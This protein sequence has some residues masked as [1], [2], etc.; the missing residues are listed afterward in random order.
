MAVAA[1]VLSRAVPSDPPTCWVVF[2][3]ALATPESAVADLGQGGAAEG[4]EGQTETHAHQDLGRQ[5]MGQKDVCTPI[6]VSQAKPS[7]PTSRPTDHR[8]PGPDAGHQSRRGGRGHDD[9]AGEGEEGHARPSGPSSAGP[10][11]SSS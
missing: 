1:I 2:T 4:G 5:D 8:H 3:R 11:A 7:A 6:W 9:A 10:A